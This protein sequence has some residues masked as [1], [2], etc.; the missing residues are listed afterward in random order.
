[1]F[2]FARQNNEQKNSDFVIFFLATLIPFTVFIWDLLISIDY[3]AKSIKYT[4]ATRHRMKEYKRM[5][6]WSQKQQMIT[7]EDF[8]SWIVRS[9]DVW[10][11]KDLNEKKWIFLENAIR[12]IDFWRSEILFCYFQLESNYRLWSDL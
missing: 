10:Y 11:W 1:V 2:S 7:W 6:R 8:Q 4:Y 5:K 3:F 12:C 9:K